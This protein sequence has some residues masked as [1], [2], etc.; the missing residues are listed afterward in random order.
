MVFYLGWLEGLIGIKDFHEYFFD[1]LLKLN[2]VVLYVGDLIVT[3]GQGGVVVVALC[4]LDEE[5]SRRNG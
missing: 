2:S 5:Q 4:A 1:I 3:D